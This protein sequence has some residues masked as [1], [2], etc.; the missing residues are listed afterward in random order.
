MFLKKKNA[1]GMVQPEAGAT[2]GPISYEHVLSLSKEESSSAAQENYS[3]GLSTELRISKAAFHAGTG[4]LEVNGWCL[5]PEPSFDLLLHVNG[6][7][8]AAEVSSGSEERQDVFKK[9][10]QYGNKRSGWRV[11]IPVENLPE[12]A[13][14]RAVYASA[15]RSH[16]HDKA[17]I[18]VQPG[19]APQKESFRIRKC[20]YSPLRSLCMIDG[21][22]TTEREDLAFGVTLSGGVPVR[23]LH[24]WVSVPNAKGERTVKLSFAAAG[25]RD[26]EEMTVTETGNPA[27]T[28]TAAVTAAKDS[29]RRVTATTPSVRQNTAPAEGALSLD[30]LVTLKQQLAARSKPSKEAGEI[31]YFPAFDGTAALSDHFHRAGWYLTGSGSPVTKVTLAGPGA[32]AD[33]APAPDYFASRSL[34]TETLELTAPGDAYL[35]ALMRAQT[36][37]VWRPLPPGLQR[38]LARLLGK[39]NIITVATHDPASVEYGNYCRSPWMLL[40]EPEKA[41]LLQESQQRFRTALQEQREAGKTCSA[42]FGTG[43]SVDRA[44]EFDFSSCMTVACNSIVAN[45]A[46]LDHIQPAFICA[47]DAVS[48]FGVSQYAETF[49]AD[50]IKVLQER[51]IYFFTSAAIGFLLI[52][53]HPEI[54]DRVI[55]CEQR[56]SGLNTDLENNWA[57]PRFDSTLNIHMLPVAATFSDTVYL[58][59]LDGRDP[60]PDNNEDFWA[61]SKAAQYHDLV[62]SGHLAHPTFAVNRAQA[63]EDRYLASV[64]ESFMAG[65]A[66]GKSFFALAGSFT[67]AVHARPAAPHCFETG[68][69][70][71]LRKLRPAVPEGSGTAGKRA[72]VVMQMN[73]RHF[74]GGRY[75]GTMLAEAM[76]GFCGEVV[77]WT[78]NMPPWS[79]DL[80]SSPGHARVQYWINDFLRAPE[81]HFDY[82]VIL[83]DGSRN[84]GMYYRVFEKAQSCNA[85]TVFINFESPNWF[86]ALS[87][88]PKKLADADNWF[89]ASC[90][91][92]IVLSSAETAI[93]FAESYYQTLFH[94]PAFAA[95]PPAIN[96]PVA[97]LVKQQNFSREKQIVLISRF[98]NVSAHKNIDAVFDC[99]TPEMQGYTLALIAGTSDLPDAQTL[100]AFRARLEGAGLSLKLLY[101][102]SDRQKYEEIAKSELMIF[103]SLFEGFGYPPVE[104]GYMGTPCIAYDLPVLQEFNS[105]HVHFVP[106]GDTAALR[107]KISELLRLPH[108]D[109]IRSAAPRVL[110]TASLNSF[111]QNLQHILDTT[112]AAKAAAGFSREK[113]ELARKVYLDGCHEPELSYGVMSEAEL[114]DLA[115]R[116]ARYSR[117]AAEALEKL[118][119]LPLRNSTGTRP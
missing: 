63:T 17:I 48:H 74:S 29:P 21:L 104:A 66:V 49:R 78:N 95:A 85:K 101:M 4:V 77:V 110:E 46:L 31:C 33:I 111:S 68:R 8:I 27:N 51:G 11:R 59:G 90:F 30:D 26:K 69:T 15:E 54:R 36:I 105:D 45:D 2:P 89:A 19:A 47:G 82:V 81:G 16:F 35:E 61:H 22:I 44:F 83:P 10:P 87:P 79:G 18:R 70:D 42:V 52:Q 112:P 109:R 39:P 72:L 71:G 28:A 94:A 12:N 6:T 106:W 14:V 84:P 116:Y 60:N 7:N 73:R 50:L 86:N 115:S 88:A 65:E 57:L 56:F 38:Y 62:N 99:I 9:Y 67:P 1:G 96:S 37:L 13:S 107:A 40:P 5:T 55:L 113:F 34:D 3:A 92:D 103:P 100:A 117:T 91:S 23:E 114:R 53:K 75:H 102:I 41:A 43:P 97:D 64:Q 119:A 93:P 118:Q 98:G 20:T 24:S 32:K 58:L 80:S 25:M 76:A 108:Q